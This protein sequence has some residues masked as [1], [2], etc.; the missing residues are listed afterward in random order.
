LAPEIGFAIRFIEVLAGGDLQEVLDIPDDSFDPPLLVGPPGGAGMDGKAIVSG[1]VQ[2]LGVEGDLRGPLED[3]AFKVVIPMAVGDPPDFL[4]SSQVPIQEELQG[5]AGIE[6][7]EQIPRVS[8][9]VHESIE[10]PGGNPPLH[11]VDLSLFSG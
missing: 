7:E 3:H 1:K 4:K 2:E 6:V 11:P 10:D 5:V 9:K 8:Q